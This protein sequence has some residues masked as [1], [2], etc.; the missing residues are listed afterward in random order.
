MDCRSF[1]AE[2]EEGWN[3]RDLDRIMSYYRDDV[4]FRSLKA[5]PI[6]G[7][8]EVRASPHSEHT[9]P[10]PS[11]SNRTFASPSRTC[12]KGMRCLSSPTLTTAARLPRKP[13]IST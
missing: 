11:T 3:S 8:G 2:W 1:A 5:I 13:Y 4:V 12:S 7:S 10:P 6:T 9:G